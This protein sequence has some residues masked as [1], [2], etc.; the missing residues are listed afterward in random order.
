MSIN[1]VVGDISD[2]IYD[3]ANIMKNNDVGFVPIADKNHVVGVV[4][5]RDIVVRGINNNMKLNTNIEEIMTS[6]IFTINEHSDLS[7]ALKIMGD[8]QLKRLLVLNGKKI[9]G[10][11]S[12]SDIIKSSSYDNEIINSL[13]KIEENNHSGNI[14]YESKIDE[15]YL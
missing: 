6:H 2:S 4:T 3:I 10:V 14:N 1:L 5:D 11:I 12:I 8:K 7:S 13:K 9:V 15:F